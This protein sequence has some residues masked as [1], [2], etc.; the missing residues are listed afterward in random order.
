MKQQNEKSKSENDDT[1][2]Q[3]SETT[4]HSMEVSAST[5]STDSHFLVWHIMK[6]PKQLKPMLRNDDK[7]DT[8][9]DNTKRICIN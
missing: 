2:S 4:T 8:I 6:W 1:L 9:C 3:S 7:E 5:Q